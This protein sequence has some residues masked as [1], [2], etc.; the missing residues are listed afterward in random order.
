MEREDGDGLQRI[1]TVLK[2]AHPELVITKRRLRK[3]ESIECV[4]L[5]RDTA[6][7]TSGSLRGPSCFVAYR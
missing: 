2:Q 1:G 5:K 6:R 4:R 3:I 7:Q